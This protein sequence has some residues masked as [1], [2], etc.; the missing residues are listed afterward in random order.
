MT[1]PTFAQ[2]YRARVEAADDHQWSRGFFMG[3]V[4]GVCTTLAILV[5]AGVLL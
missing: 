4:A 2:R 3:L 5:V 1:R